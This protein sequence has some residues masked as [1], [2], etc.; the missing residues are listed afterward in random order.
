M[1]DWAQAIR[2]S[3]S[4]DDRRDRTHVPAPLARVDEALSR[5]GS[6]PNVA[7]PTDLRERILRRIADEPPQPLAGPW[8]WKP[9]ALAAALVAI[10]SVTAYTLIPSPPSIA[11]P[12]P[13][14]IDTPA[15]LD[16]DASYLT[17]LPS[18]A[19][20]LALGM[21]DPLLDEARFMGED[22]KR[23]AQVLL[24]R[25]PTRLSR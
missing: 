25:L 23:A 4:L 22:T 10:A 12:G 15:P 16:L 5:P 8:A 7:T 19:E 13:I 24:A 3:G 9:L 6:V 11:T 17:Q 2:I 21:G 1:N 14:A 20:P 18:K